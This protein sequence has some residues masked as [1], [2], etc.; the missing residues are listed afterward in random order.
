MEQQRSIVIIGGGISGLS[1][2]T[3]IK[4]GGFNSIILE[5]QAQPG[6][7]LQTKFEQE[8]LLELG[9]NTTTSNLALEELVNIVGLQNE[10]ITPDASA[11]KRYIVKK[12]KLR[13][14]SPKAKDILLSSL[15]SISGK[16]SVY[17]EQFQPAKEDYEEES[18]GE[19][20]E[21][22]FSKEVV[23]YIVNPMIAGI[24]AGDPYQLSMRSV[25]PQ[26]IDFEQD[27]GSVIKGLKAKQQEVGPRKMVSFARGMGSFITA[28]V[29]Y[30][31]EENILC[32]T[33]ATKVIP[34]ENGQFAIQLKQGE[35]EVE[36]VADVVVFATPSYITAE[37]LRPISNE[38]ANLMQMPYPPLAVVHL[39]YDKAAF[40]QP[41]DSFGFLVPEKEQKHLLGAIANSTFLP[42][43]APADKQ[44]FT[45]Y[46]GG[47]RHQ[48]ELEQNADQLIAK[49][50][51][52]F[53]ELVGVEGQPEFQSVTIWEKSIPQF[54]MNHQQIKE[55]FEF[56]EANVDNLHILGNYRS[57]LSVADCVQGAKR[58][59]GKLIKDYSRQSYHASKNQSL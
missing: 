21:R 59:H 16:W 29:N 27:H 32:N 50:I 25:F 6:G 1:L 35:T 30:I 23:D 3:Y 37:F 22:R 39:G 41:F 28:M 17:K 13:K 7:V 47:T 10:F 45:L 14:L 24:Y 43:R 15:L 31:G 51:T 49:A 55:G 2:G 54:Q 52:E 5:K 11:N 34:L 44:L 42:N 57:G 18:V 9:A 53:Q 20:F 56:F 38:L 26:V 58:T 40:K 4:D 46:V 8:Y 33:E 48:K 19:F 36:I 12:N